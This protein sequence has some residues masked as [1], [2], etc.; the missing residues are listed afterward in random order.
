[1][2]RVKKPRLKLI[3]KIKK[4]DIIEVQVQQKYPSITGL[5]TIGDSDDFMRKEPAVYL[6]E[7]TAYFNEEVVG[8]FLMSSA[9]SANPRITFP[10]RVD[11]SGTLKVVFKSNGV[12]VFE[13]TKEIS[14]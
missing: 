2:A 6:K 7:M 12:D 8:T 11:K 3:T 1:M 10:L 4:G 9:I 14:L 5:A 13:S